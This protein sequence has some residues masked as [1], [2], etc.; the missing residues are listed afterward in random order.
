M[1]T[2]V[3]APGDLTP[4]SDLT[5]ADLLLERAS[6]IAELAL[7]AEEHLSLNR[8]QA[9]L[10]SLSMRYLDA[11]YALKT[12]E[13]RFPDTNLTELRNQLWMLENEGHLAC[14]LREGLSLEQCTAL[15]ADQLD[16][17]TAVRKTIAKWEAV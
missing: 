14:Y 12:A 5:H 3:P 2:T 13:V 7:D 17:I 9:T 16:S 6:I 11:L 10:C 1:S 15:V 8:W 4:S